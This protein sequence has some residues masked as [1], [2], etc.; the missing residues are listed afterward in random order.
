MNSIRTSAFVA[1]VLAATLLASLTAQAQGTSDALLERGRYLMRGIVGCGNCHSSRT[2][3]GELI[4][5]M[6]LAGNFVITEPGFSAYAPNITPDMRTGIGSWTDEEI[7]R[8]VREGV[9]PDGRVLGPPMS[10]VFYRNISDNDMRAIVAYL[11]SVPAVEHE[12]PASTYDIPLPPN[13]GPPVGSVP[14]VPR[15][16][17]V[18]YGGYLTN[19]LGHCTDCHTPLVNGQH[20]FSRRGAGGN[21]FHN[22]FG[23]EFSALAA[24]ITQH[25]TM[26]IGEWTDEEIKRAITQGIS[27]DGR[28]LLP[29]MAFSFYKN[30]SNEDLDAIVAYLRTLP[31]AVAF[32]PQ[33]Q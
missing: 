28:E 5:G 14:D 19:A 1:A 9:R 10:F 20:D 23:Y 31:P 21:V 27:R 12:V 13:W 8:A 30:I 32:P 16:D 26:G 17:K 18:V 33:E 11:R 24:N 7:I 29:F 6:E 15:D 25:P 3:D 4:E 22:P 2:P